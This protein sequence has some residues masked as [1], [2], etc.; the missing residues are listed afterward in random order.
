MV[1]AWLSTLA[2]NTYVLSLSLQTRT[3]DRGHCAAAAAL[4][5]AHSGKFFF[6]VS[7][8]SSNTEAFEYQLPGITCAACTG[9]VFWRGSTRGGV[10]WG[11]LAN[12]FRAQGFG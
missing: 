7:L 9:F 4:Q 6:I 1:G 5:A 11:C 10:G 12:S 3:A 8:V 2:S